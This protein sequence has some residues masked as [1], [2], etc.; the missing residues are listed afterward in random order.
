M[1]FDIDR[2]D[3][4]LQ[5]AAELRERFARDAVDRDK[6]GGQPLDQ[7]A[8]LKESGLLK[9][10]IPGEYGGDGQP[11]S[12]ALRIVRE[13][14]KVDGS[15][16][17]LYGYHT[18]AQHAAYLRG[19]GRQAAEL[20]AASV[21]G[22]WF[23]SNNDNSRANTLKGRRE[24]DH[25]IL[26]GH[27]PFTSGSHIADHVTITWLDEDSGK[28]MAG[29]IPSTRAGWK[30]LNDW[31]AFG[32]RQTGSGT[33]TYENVRVEAA[34]VYQPEASE[35]E[36]FRTLIPFTQ[37]SVLLNVFIGSAQGALQAARD[38]TVNQSRPWVHSGVDR[39]I[40]DPWVKRVY[41]DM[42]TKTLAATM[43]AD[44]ALAV[45]DRVWSRSRALTFDERGK[46]AVRLAAANAFAGNTALE[47]TSRIFEVM[48]ARSTS[49]S[50]GLDRFWRNI[51]THTL[52]NPEEYKTRNVGHWVLTGEA[53]VPS[54]I[55]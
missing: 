13:F 9:L 24:G 54:G 44:E 51:R 12:K 6:A 23:W 1:D 11:W 14:A 8:L 17:H 16:A 46:A 25:W 34:E 32:Q 53:P 19:N 30:S 5:K 48:G 42:Y 35:A 15:L 29:A 18:G 37:Q 7:L 22:N 45:F 50:L 40:D 3:P 41:G 20:Y 49:N 55:Q 52:H 31:D 38:Y 27:K 39:H 4:Y 36:A 21:R 47:V 43:L 2:N 26:N 33:C 28:T 10:T